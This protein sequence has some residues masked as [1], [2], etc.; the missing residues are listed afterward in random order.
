[1]F[2]MLCRMINKEFNLLF[3]WYDRIFF[4]KSYSLSN[5]TMMIEQNTN[6]QNQI[7]HTSIIFYRK[8]LEKENY[9]CPFLGI[10][11]SERVMPLFYYSWQHVATN[12]LISQT[13][14]PPVQPQ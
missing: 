11:G 6:I 14:Q 7:T 10:P 4:V 5:A 1:M 3:L 2:V 12:R 9:F 13:T 8:S